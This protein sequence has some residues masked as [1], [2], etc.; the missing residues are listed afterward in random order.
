MPG[1]M[2]T[3]FGLVGKQPRVI[4]ATQTEHENA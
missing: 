3:R 2:C 1:R 4:P